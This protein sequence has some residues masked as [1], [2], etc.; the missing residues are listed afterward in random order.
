MRNLITTIALL[1]LLSSPGAIAQTTGSA[2]SSAELVSP[3]V[4]TSMT[5]D[6]RLIGSAPIG[7]RQPR[8]SDVPSENPNDLDYISAE[9]AAVDRKINNICRGC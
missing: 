6:T 1:T 5:S 2:R 7:H 9:D 8:A 3:I 4:G